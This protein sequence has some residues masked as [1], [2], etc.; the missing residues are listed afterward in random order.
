MLSACLWYLYHLCLKITWHWGLTSSCPKYC[1][2]SLLGAKR[3][4]SFLQRLTIR[5]HRQCVHG[6]KQWQQKIG[7]YHLLINQCC[8]NCAANAWMSWVH[9]FQIIKILCFPYCTS[10]LITEKWGPTKST[11][12]ELL[13]PRKSNDSFVP[14]L[15]MRAMKYTP[16]ISYESVVRVK[17]R[18]VA[19]LCHH[20]VITNTTRQY[21]Q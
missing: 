13:E 14:M 10:N 20:N 3:P 8:R 17:L 6:I 12:R 4:E 2:A 19:V 21:Q 9:F 18:T 1:M 5:Q 11:T 16:R 15:Q 7:E